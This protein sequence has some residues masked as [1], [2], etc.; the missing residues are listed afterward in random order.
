MSLLRTAEPAEEPVTLAEAKLHMG[1]TISEHDALIESL[2][3]AARMQAEARCQRTLI[4]TEWTLT[5]DA[6][7]DDIRLPMP[8]VTAITSVSYVDT[9]GVTQALAGADY[10]L[11]HAGELA[12][13]IVPAYGTSWP[14]TRDQANAVVV[15]Y[16]AGVA[17]AASVPDDIKVWIKMIVGQW[18]EFREAGVE[19]AVSVLPS[20]FWD[21]LLDPYRVLG[22]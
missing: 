22:I 4:D 13:W 5:L 8:R 20:P 19:R 6:F 3:K 21:G 1:V 9:A 14:A 12:N 10:Y 17:D 15:V 11:E 7:P 16:R 18:Y 2:I